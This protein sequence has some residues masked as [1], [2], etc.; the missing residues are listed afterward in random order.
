MSEKETREKIHRIAM[1]EFQEKGF[2]GASLR[3]IVKE[4]GV[5]TGAF[6]GY[7]KSKEELFEALVGPIAEFFLKHYDD[8]QK[9][10]NT[11]S[12]EEQVA[13]MGSYSER[14]A[15]DGMEYAYKHLPQMKLLL[16]SAAGTRYENFLHELVEKEIESTHNFMKFMVKAGMPAPNINTIFE[17]TITSGMYNSFFEL[18][19]HDVPY[20]EA[21]KC[22]MEITKFYQ[23]GWSAYMGLE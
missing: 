1:Q 8:I 20:E 10:F 4:A 11:L 13:L 16:T 7:Y 17:H 5:T 6:Y 12:P 22:A 21:M 3:N 2:K 23:A 19:V 9:N 15:K 14:Y 18:I